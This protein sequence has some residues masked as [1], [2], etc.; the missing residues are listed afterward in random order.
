MNGPGTDSA[1]ATRDF[2]VTPDGFTHYPSLRHC[3][4]LMLQL[5]GWMVASV[6]AGAI[7]HIY[8]TGVVPRVVHLL[9]W[10]V[11]L[12]FGIAVVIGPLLF[13]VFRRQRF[14]IDATGITSRAARIAWDEVG[15]ARYRRN[16][17][18]PTLTLV[19]ADGARTVQANVFGLADLDLY[20]QLC[21]F[22]GADHAVTR[23]IT[24]PEPE[25]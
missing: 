23:A 20:I 12:V 5:G 6:L 9:P 16:V 10:L 1:H 8:Y 4:A 18:L 11:L 17:N 25:S 19:S 7:L 15:T 21:R 24:N 14:S 22:A 3:I 13:M 2:L